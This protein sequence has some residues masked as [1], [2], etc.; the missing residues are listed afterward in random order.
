MVIGQQLREG[1][2]T[3]MVPTFNGDFMEIGDNQYGECLTAV[4]N[5]EPCPPRE[6]DMCVAIRDRA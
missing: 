5:D 1:E 2:D 6:E 4:M 3:E